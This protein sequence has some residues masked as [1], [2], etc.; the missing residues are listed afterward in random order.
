MYDNNMTITFIFIIYLIQVTDVRI[1]ID[2]ETK[3]H[4]GHCY[5]DLIDPISVEA[6]LAKN[7]QVN[8]YIIMR[9]N[10]CCL[11]TH[12]IFF[13]IYIYSFIK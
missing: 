13:Y 8:I 11:Y 5:V 3:Q 6:A 10:N 9:N 1:P 7:G 2:H 4:K 12:A